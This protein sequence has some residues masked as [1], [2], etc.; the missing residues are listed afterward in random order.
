MLRPRTDAVGPW[1]TIACA[2]A[3]AAILNLFGCGSSDMGFRGAQAGEDASLLDIFSNRQTS[4]NAIEDALNEFDA[5]RRRSGLARIAAE[6]WGGEPAYVDFYRLAIQDNDAAVR[7]VAARALALHG[8]REDALPVAELLTDDDR[9][10]RWSAARALQRLHN[11]DVTNALIRR[12]MPEVEDDV[13]V[14]EAAARALGQY[15]EARVLQALISA[16]DDS[17]L[18]VNAAAKQSLELLTGEALGYAPEDWSRWVSASAAPF[19]NRAEYVYPAFER[20]ARWFETV[21][22]FYEVPNETGT[23]PTGMPPNVAVGAGS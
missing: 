8:E 21:N 3:L 13:L 19:T 15:A 1:R 11:P 5:D 18:A 22:P 17:D 16:L 2:S 20:E 9:L 7:G 12:T 4:T 14:R 6:P 10:V 23:R